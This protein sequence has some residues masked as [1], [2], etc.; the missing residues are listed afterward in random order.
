MKYFKSQSNFPKKKIESKI[1]NENF[2][3][4]SDPSAP[5]VEQGQGAQP[6]SGALSR[7]SVSMATGSILSRQPAPPR[8]GPHPIASTP[9][10][11]ALPKAM[12]CT[13]WEALPVALR[14]YSRGWL[15]ID[16]LIA[17]LVGLFEFSFFFK[18]V[19]RIILID[20]SWVV[21]MN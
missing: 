9:A 1:Q 21:K 15:Y 14:V 3:K 6:P 13:V 19:R 16:L 20:R 2:H 17:I 8:T 7:V 5:L 18:G 12:G 10:A 11:P 4:H